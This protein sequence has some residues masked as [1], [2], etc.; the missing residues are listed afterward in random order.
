VQFEHRWFKERKQHRDRFTL[1]HRGLYIQYLEWWET[2]GITQ[3]SPELKHIKIRHRFN[4]DRPARWHKGDCATC[5]SACDI[6]CTEHCHKHAGHVLKM[7]LD[8]AY[9]AFKLDS[10][11]VA[12]H[13]HRSMFCLLR[14]Y[15]AIGASDNTFLC[16]YH[17]RMRLYLEAY[18]EL[19]QE[20]H[21]DCSCECGFCSD[22]DY[23]EHIDEST[24]TLRRHVLCPKPPGS[25]YYKLECVT[26]Q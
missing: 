14:P 26:N 1:Q 3:Q 19:S 20:V 6:D 12:E 18:R 5:S 17:A 8:D 22:G 11:G 24:E 21:Q 16:V 25:E 15:W 2:S 4:G 7:L 23:A 10:P 13:M 9:E